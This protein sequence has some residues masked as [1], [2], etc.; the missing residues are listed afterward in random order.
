MMAPIYKKVA[1][2]FVDKAVFVKIDTNAQYELSSRYG[3]RS[4]PTFQWFVSGSKIEPSR[5]YSVYAGVDSS[6]RQP[7]QLYTA[8]TR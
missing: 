6:K 1:K 4:L 3:I 7:A 2:E 5:S 8:K